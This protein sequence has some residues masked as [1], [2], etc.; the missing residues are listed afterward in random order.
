MRRFLSSSLWL[1]SCKLVDPSRKSTGWF[2]VSLS[3]ASWMRGER[4]TAVVS[5]RASRRQASKA[6]LWVSRRA[7]ARDRRRAGAAPSCLGIN[8]EI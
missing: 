1:R 7:R 4:E 5:L 8:A 2:V 3:A 6:V